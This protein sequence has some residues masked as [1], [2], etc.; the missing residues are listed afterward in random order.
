V[1]LIKLRLDHSQASG[2]DGQPQLEL[3]TVDHSKEGRSLVLELA[4]F[5]AGFASGA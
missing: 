1:D 5:L 4:S 3:R 2:L